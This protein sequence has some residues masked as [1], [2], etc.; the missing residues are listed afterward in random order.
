MKW[1]ILAKIGLTLPIFFAIIY[2]IAGIAQLSR[3]LPCQGRG[4]ELE[5]PY[6]HHTVDD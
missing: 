6:P 4:Q 2:C 5:S 1:R 3:A